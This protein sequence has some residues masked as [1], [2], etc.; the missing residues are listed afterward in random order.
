MLSAMRQ[1]PPGVRSSELRPHVVPIRE[2]LPSVLPFPPCYVGSPATCNVACHLPSDRDHRWSA[3]LTGRRT[4]MLRTGGELD[5][6]DNLESRR[7]LFT[8]WL[9]Q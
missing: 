4:S 5:E 3:T 7:R 9:P 8:V 2:Y 1:P 6:L